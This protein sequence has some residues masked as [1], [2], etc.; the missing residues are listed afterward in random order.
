MIGVA[1]GQVTERLP[2]VHCI[3][4]VAIGYFS[5]EKAGV[6]LNSQLRADQIL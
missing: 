1:G 6:G 3:G 5:R 4:S 2:L